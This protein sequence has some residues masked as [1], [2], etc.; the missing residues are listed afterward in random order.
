MAFEE[1]TTRA[2]PRTPF[3][4]LADTEKRRKIAEYQ[5]QFR[6]PCPCHCHLEE[7]GI[8]CRCI[9]NCE[10]CRPSAA[11]STTTGPADRR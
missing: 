7:K 5:A 6:M 11:D 4:E 9:K 8:Q 2:K 3:D 1:S 10:H